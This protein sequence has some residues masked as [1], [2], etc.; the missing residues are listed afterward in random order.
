[1]CFPP[2]C[3]IFNTVGRKN[4]AQFLAQSD[5]FSFR[6]FFMVDLSRKRKKKR[7]GKLFGRGIST[8]FTYWLHI[9]DPPKNMN[10]LVGD[11]STYLRWERRS[12]AR[13]CNKI[14]AFL[15][16]ALSVC[17]NPFRHL[18]GWTA[19]EF[20]RNFPPGL[21]DWRT[22]LKIF[23]SRNGSSVSRL[24]RWSIAAYFG[25]LWNWWNF[26]RQHHLSN[27]GFTPTN[28]SNCCRN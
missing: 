7:G 20:K 8:I 13:V 12:P 2:I 24:Y 11:S 15:G 16:W 1:M 23:I 22:K 28:R 14:S 21:W 25:K 5:P 6:I 18:K 9:T 27:W 19:Y 10:P 26:S 17:V 4:R 3:F